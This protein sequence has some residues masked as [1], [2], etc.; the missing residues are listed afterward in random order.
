MWLIRFCD[1]ISERGGSV[2]T[3]T[4]SRPFS[5]VAT[6]GSRPG[7][8]DGA[9]RAEFACILGL[10]IVALALRLGGLDH[11]SIWYDEA[12]TL[13]LASASSGDLASGRV[14]D[15]GNPQGYF[16]LLHFWLCLWHST[17]IET[18]RAFSAV[19]GT[20][21]VPAIW[22]LARCAGARRRAGLL[23]C[24]LV[25]FSPP[26]V[27]L[28]QEAR[29]FAL[30]AT[31]ATVMTAAVAAICNGGRR[32]SWV[33]FAVCGAVLVHLH[34]YGPLLL[35][36]VGLYLLAWGWRHDRSVVWKLFAVALLVALAFAPC[37]PLFRRQLAE[38][39]ARSPE[40]WWQHLALLPLF[41]V[42]GRTLVWKAAGNGTVAAVDLAILA[43]LYVPLFGLA[44]R[45]RLSLGPVAAVA[46]GLPL[47]AGVISLALTP[48]IH[49]HYLAP[50][51]PALLLLTAAAFEA[52]WRQ[53]RWGLLVG[54]AL[55]L[56]IVSPMALAGVYRTAHKTDWRSL[57]ARVAER[58][59]ELPTYF[60][61]DLGRE[62]FV[63]YRPGQT[64][65][66]IT[67]PF[68]NDGEPWT[69]AGLFA[70]FQAEPKGFWL[71]FY[72]TNGQTRS[73]EAALFKRLERD[74]HVDHDERFGLMRLLRCR[75]QREPSK[76]SS[77]RPLSAG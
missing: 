40:T 30:F 23:A 43:V 72:A 45:G 19:A 13:R 67:V 34:Y 2:A 77:P 52:G 64:T 49:S 71:V 29:V 46:L 26:L 12:V 35:I 15:E 36:V 50:A 20:L 37:L 7:F 28:S 58:D 48:L 75:P 53:R 76:G 27:Y 4:L 47:L 54:P 69:Q 24:V 5:P 10:M 3:S 18:A 31:V 25:T 11:E 41:S 38:G 73:E 32:A 6:D 44:W 51:V 9:T 16:L 22:L 14:A 56:G 55:V 70:R 8:A 42:A 74:C 17:S 59:A 63:Y 39:S 21:I 1:P 61:E 68:G 57:A 33:S 65:H 60:Y 66:V 62:P